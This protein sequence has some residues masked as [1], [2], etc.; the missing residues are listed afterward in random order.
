MTRAYKLIRGNDKVSFVVDAFSDV[1]SRTLRF[2]CS[3][4]SVPIANERLRVITTF[5]CVYFLARHQYVGIRDKPQ[6]FGRRQA[7]PVST[8]SNCFEINDVSVV[9]WKRRLVVGC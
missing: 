6:S 8:R 1:L 5:F 4:L 2:G 7:H 3:A 9:F